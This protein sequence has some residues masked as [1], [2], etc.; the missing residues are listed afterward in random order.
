VNE[1]KCYYR[2][3]LYACLAYI[4]FYYNLLLGSHQ[5][6]RRGTGVDKEKELSAV[7]VSL[8]PQELKDMYLTTVLEHV[9]VGV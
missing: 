1:F 9:R 2:I 4:L 6:R 7:M 3:F 5:R 8:L